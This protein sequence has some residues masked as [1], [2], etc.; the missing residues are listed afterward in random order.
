MQNV[1]RHND[2]NNND[3]NNNDTAAA[4]I[5]G[6][7]ITELMLVLGLISILAA[8]AF[9]TYFSSTYEAHRKAAQSEMQ[10]LALSLERDFT[11]TDV[12]T[13]LITTGEATLPDD[14]TRHY[15]IAIQTD[16]HGGHYVIIATPIG[17]QAQDSCGVLQLTSKGGRKAEH[18]DCWE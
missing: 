2:N 11:L 16:A 14:V 13:D 4:H 18:A 10:I 15:D 3:N 9:P 12:Y 5:S 8:I 7:T 1:S 17:H 6:F